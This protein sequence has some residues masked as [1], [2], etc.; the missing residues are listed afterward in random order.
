M[1]ERGMP[2]LEPICFLVLNLIMEFW[3]IIMPKAHEPKFVPKPISF[4][5]DIEILGN[6]S[7]VP[8]S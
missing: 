6:G 2:K 8:H 1:E 5:E 3:I 4:E 7:L